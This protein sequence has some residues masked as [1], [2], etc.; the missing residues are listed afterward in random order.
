MALRV[1]HVGKF[2]P[3]VHGGIETFLAD[4]VRAQRSQGIEAFALVHGDPIPD[5]PEWLVRVPVLGHLLYAPIAPR[6]R[7]AL[8][9]AIERFQPQVLHFHK[10]NN[11]V[12]WALTL[13]SARQ[14]P[15]IVHWHSDVLFP[16]DKKIQSWAYQLYR[17]FEQA[18]LGRAE[19]ILVTS[20]PYLQ[21]SRSLVEYR[22]KC[23]V[24]PLGLRAA[25]TEQ[26]PATEL[27]WRDGRLRLLSIGRLAHYKGFETL[28][29]AVAGQ[30]GMDLVIA[31]SGELQA[32]LA[33][34]IK[35]TTPAGQEPSAVLLG[36]VSDPVKNALLRSCDVF[37][38]ASRERTE[39][40]GVVLLEAMLYSRPCL[41]SDL[42]GSG[43][44]WVVQQAQCGQLVKLDN[45]EAW[46]SAIASYAT[47]PQARLQDGNAGQRAFH[48]RFTADACARALT[49]HYALLAG[50]MQESPRK[51]DLLIVIPARNEAHTIGKL[52][53]SLREAG[54][55]HVLVVDDQSSDET[56][57]VARIAGASVIRP[58]LHMGAWGATQ[59]GIRY[60]QL[61]G[62]RAVITMDADGQHEVSGIE[63]LLG[64]ADQAD[65]VIGAF[66]AR[67]SKARRIA[68][69]WFTHLT[70]L[71]FEDL[72][73]GFRYYNRAAIRIL[74]SE[75][76]TLLDYQDVGTL[77]MVRRAGLQI[78]E[79]P[80]TMKLR[81]T[82]KSRIFNSWFSV[83][84]YMGLTTLLCLSRWRVKH[85]TSLRVAP[86]L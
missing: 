53:H 62:Y 3:P 31:G 63:Q 39:A 58:V 71:D 14:I 65:L 17:P 70:G 35:S 46:R 61:K 23:A 2:Y 38:L 24:V 21:A 25:P 6:F 78:C 29:R 12:F 68:W 45:V 64:A 5:D 28:I 19:R 27:P 7:S 60:A 85:A 52:L 13:G 15:W 81:T 20:P 77:L 32:E 59:T 79:V 75:E 41:V 8:D 18:M 84:R 10:P 50:E 76:A 69:R 42:P 74:V 40:F 48:E 55:C 49:P 11:S 67:A 30:R 83:G 73:S 72:T 86:R 57:S 66:A 44:P 1:L 26:L 36:E 80:V 56:S 33:A 9:R 4:L 22:S 43:M 82:G 16:D 34:L 54:W 37:C 51:D 47:N